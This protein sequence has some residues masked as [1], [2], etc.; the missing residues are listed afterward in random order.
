[1]DKKMHKKIN[2]LYEISNL[3]L[4]GYDLKARTGIFRVIE[5]IIEKIQDFSSLEVQF[6]SCVSL[7]EA[8]LTDYYLNNERKN[9]K[10][11]SIEL[12]NLMFGSIYL[13]I[14]KNIHN[15]KSCTLSNR[16]ARKVQ[17]KLLKVIQNIAITKKVDKEFKIYH[18]FFFPLPNLSKFGITA[19]QRIITVYDL[20][21][22]LMPQFFTEGMQGFFLR[23]L[24]PSIEIHQ[25]WVI[26]IS[27]STK[28]D[29]CRLTGMPE[30]RVFVTHLGASNNFYKES[31]TDKIQE[32]LDK[33]NIPQGRYILGL[34]TLEP[35]KNTAHL[36]RCF[37]KILLENKYD[38]VYLVLAGSKG[39]LYEEIFQ[40][41]DSHSSLKDKVI[42]TGFIDDKDLSSIYSGAS[43]F[44][45]PSLYEGFGLPPLEAMQCGLP[46]I[47]SNNSSLPEVVGDAGI[48]VNATDESQ[49]CQAMTKLLN[50]PNLCQQLSKQALQQSQNFSWEKCA[51]ET[52]AIYQHIL[53]K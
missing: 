51:A 22:V 2:I 4:G 29:F 1:M 49:L 37:F 45:Y 9:W 15:N 20:I 13:K 14:L 39:W 26:C 47:T 46:V 23:E 44:V 42:F 25:D 8:I 48:M 31:N 5:N 32:T 30:E 33:Y 28:K 17:T 34:S 16:I 53:E 11:Q 21:P 27:H 10:P 41:A 19:K 43:F 3:G 40:T 52:I 12:W 7:N 36:I 18:S 50:D 6:T 38:D 35:R 24:I